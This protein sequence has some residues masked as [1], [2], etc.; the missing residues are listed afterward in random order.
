MHMCPRGKH[1]VRAGLLDGGQLFLPAY[2]PGAVD[3]DCQRAFLTLIHRWT[4]RGIAVSRAVFKM[5]G[6]RSC[7]FDSEAVM[8]DTAGGKLIDAETCARIVK[9]EQLQSWTLI[10][11]VG[12]DQPCPATAKQNREAQR[13]PKP[14]PLD[15]VRE[16]DFPSRPGTQPHRRLL[17]SRIRAVST[18][19][20]S[21]LCKVR[22]KTNTFHTHSSPLRGRLRSPL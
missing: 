6:Q 7:P 20:V 16:K 5:Q 22:G 2:L 13:R 11:D 21:L 8:V 4:I 17:R 12:V 18:A 10:H 14:Q 1:P 15:N 3:G 9:L 19:P